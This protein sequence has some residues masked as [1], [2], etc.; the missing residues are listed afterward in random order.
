MARKKQSRRKAV[1][2]QDYT[3]E[4]PTQKDL[5][6]KLREC[7]SEPRKRLKEVLAVARKATTAV[8]RMIAAA[9]LRAFWDE[10]LDDLDT[11]E[12]QTEALNYISTTRLIMEL[13]FRQTASIAPPELRSVVSPVRDESRAPRPHAD[14]MGYRWCLAAY[15]DPTGRDI[16]V[17]ETALR[18]TANTIID[19]CRQIESPA[20]T[21]P[22]PEIEDVPG[23]EDSLVL[24]LKGNSR[25]LLLYMWKRGNITREEVR[26]VLHAERRKKNPNAEPPTDKAV[27]DAIGYF[28]S[29]LKAGGLLRTKLIQNGGMFRLSHPQN[30]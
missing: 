11:R 2:D 23:P 26:S 8:A 1:A 27:R 18:D 14:I 6:R 28:D 25:A 3:L 9:K 19:W 16:P 12:T 20:S 24:R 15:T 4:F 7:T 22:S 29:A 17:E 21:M 5:L 13:L 10:R 30:P